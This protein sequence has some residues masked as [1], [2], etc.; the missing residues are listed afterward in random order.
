MIRATVVMMA[1]VVR[2]QIRYTD[3]YEQ[4]KKFVVGTKW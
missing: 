1:V 3:Q 4:M 2:G